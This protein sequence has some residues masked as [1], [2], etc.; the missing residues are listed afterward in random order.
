MLNLC[1]ILTIIAVVF[2]CVKH[3]LTLICRIFVVINETSVQ[4][5]LALIIS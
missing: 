1:Y 2:I 5:D 3:F 4:N